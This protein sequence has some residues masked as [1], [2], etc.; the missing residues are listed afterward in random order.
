[1]TFL[2]AN[3]AKSTLAAPINTV[4][5]S[6]TLTAG[7]G[8]LFPNPSGGDLFVLVLTDAAT[9]NVFEVLHC[10]ARVAD[11][12]TV[13]RAQEG[14][15]ALNWTTG[16]FAN[17]VITAGTM[18][19]I[20]VNPLIAKGDLIAGG[21]S[22]APGRLAVGADG[23][24]LVADS[25]Q[26]EGLSWETVFSNP[27]T[28]KGDVIVG[29]AAG[30]PARLPVGANGQVLEADSTQTDGLK[31]ATPFTNPMTTLGDLIV[32]AAAGAPA[33]FGIGADG[34]VLTADS[35]QPDGLSWASPVAAMIPPPVNVQIGTNYTI[36]LADAPQAAGYRGTITMNNAGAN[37]LTVAPHS[38]QAWLFGTKFR[39][40]QLG[41]GITTITD[42]GSVTLL[43]ARTLAARAQNSVMEIEYIA[44]DEWSC[45]GDAA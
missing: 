22:G 39:I 31:W 21:T 23:L 17:N 3:N 41:A 38:S 26:P 42:G 36:T 18:D 8:A 32:G 2:Y 7:T 20:L 19:A 27:M 16:D 43:T 4:A 30:V 5:T 14:T 24:F 10:T 12:C 6:L 34:R 11:V 44:T 29:A 13:V 15:T 37:T 1:M 33:R 25:G 40:I 35:G 45:S 9:G 28:A